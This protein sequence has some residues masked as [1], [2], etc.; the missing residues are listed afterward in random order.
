[1]AHLMTRGAAATHA[2]K[3]RLINTMLKGNE[4]ALPKIKINKDNC[5]D[6][7]IALEH[8]E[9]VEGTKGVEKQ[10]K[11]ERNKSMMQ[12]HT[13]HLTDAFDIPVFSQ[14]YQGIQ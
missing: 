8:A 6:L 12:Q 5:K 10:K 7:I 1:V 2:E 11:D 3:Y 4:R 13:T 14:Y 9:A